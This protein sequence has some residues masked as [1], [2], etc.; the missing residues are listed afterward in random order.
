[1]PLYHCYEFVEEFSIIW[2]VQRT[3]KAI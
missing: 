3:F 2:D 1:M